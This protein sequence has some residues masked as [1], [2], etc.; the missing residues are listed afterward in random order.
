MKSLLLVII[1]INSLLAGNYEEAEKAYKKQDYK[2]AMMLYRLSAKE[3][4]SEAEC[5]IGSMYNDGA[6]VLENREKALLWYTKSAMQ[7]NKECIWYLALYYGD[8]RYTNEQNDIKAFYWYKKGASLGSEDCQDGLASAYYYE[9]GTVKD[10]KKANYWYEKAFQGFKVKA[11]N[12]EEPAMYQLSVKYHKGEGTVKN[13]EQARYWFSKLKDKTYI[14]IALSDLYDANYVVGDKV[15]NI[16]ELVYWTKLAATRGDHNAQIKLSKMYTKGIGVSKDKKEAFSWMLKAARNDGKQDLFLSSG[17][18][19]EDPNEAYTTVA[20]MY[21]DGLGTKADKKKAMFWYLKAGNN[22]DIA[23]QAYL[24]YLYLT[25]VGS[26]KSYTKAKKWLHLSAKKGSARSQ[27][28]LAGMYYRGEGVRQDYKTAMQWY[29]LS[30]NQ[31]NVRAQF[32]IGVMYDKGEGVLKDYEEAI[33]WYQEAIKNGDISSKCFLG[34]VYSKQ[35]KYK[36]AK[37]IVQEGY[38]DGKEFC[39]TVWEYYKLGEK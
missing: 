23:V 15:Q 14:S 6:G 20:T 12:G 35:H 22:G 26:E 24:G 19:K 38:S 16:E 3:G 11:V 32:N 4:D 37:K 2:T 36:L 1:L 27:Y 25:G 33:K 10:L 9:T 34:A 30:A 39:K 21:M 28:Y 13:E 5:R 31:G 17:Y 29:L 7:D 8:Y 18:K